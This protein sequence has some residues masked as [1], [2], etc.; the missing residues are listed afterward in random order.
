MMGQIKEQGQLLYRFRMED[1]QGRR[2][3]LRKREVLNMN[4]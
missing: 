2:E 1:P 3:L 4:A